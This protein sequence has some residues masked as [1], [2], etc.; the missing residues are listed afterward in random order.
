MKQQSRLE[1]L[2][3]PTYALKHTSC[4]CSDSLHGMAALRLGLGCSAL[5]FT[6]R[7]NPAVSLALAAAYHLPDGAATMTSELSYV[8]PLSLTNVAAHG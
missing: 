6:W 7:N 1:L 4:A 8:G 5:R 2:V 3:V